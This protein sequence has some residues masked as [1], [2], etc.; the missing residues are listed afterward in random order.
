MVWLLFKWSGYFG[1]FFG[2][3]EFGY[4]LNMWLFWLLCKEIYD[5]WFN[6]FCLVW[7]LFH[8]CGYLLATL[9]NWRNSFRLFTFFVSNKEKFGFSRQTCTNL[10]RVKRRVK[11]QNFKLASVEVQI[12]SALSFRRMR[13]RGR[14]QQHLAYLVVLNPVLSFWV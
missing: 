9:I 10:L 2:I 4:F 5:L 1:Y 12:M 3:G 11:T 14:E 7:L 6:Y 13:T 8:R